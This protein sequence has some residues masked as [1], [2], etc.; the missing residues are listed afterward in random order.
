M[1]PKR[2][3]RTTK[4]PGDGRFATTRVPREWANQNTAELMV[5]CNSVLVASDGAGTI[6]YTYILNSS[7]IYNFAGRFG[8]LFDEYRVMSCDLKVFPIAPSASGG[9]YTSFWWDE[10]SN[11][12][13]TA[14]EKSGRNMTIM[15]NSNSN[16]ASVKTFRWT[17]RDP[18]ELGFA[19]T[20][21]A[22]DMVFFKVYSSSAMG[23]PVST[24]LWSLQPMLHLQFRGIKSA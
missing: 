2:G 4:R 16:A 24:N 21:S 10:N 17:N 23:T 6:A 18:T 9:G 7:A 3:S 8:S 22:F 19:N 14:N 5:P 11:A 20:T 15:S 12:A 13:P 1:A